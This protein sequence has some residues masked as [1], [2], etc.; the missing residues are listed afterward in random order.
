MKE[1]LEQQHLQTILLPEHE[2]IWMDKHEIWVNN[3]MFDIHTKKLEQGIYTF[4]GLYDEEE[5]E[6]VEWERNA[7]AKN[8]EQNKQLAQFLKSLPVFYTQ[9][10]EE[11]CPTLQPDFFISFPSGIPLKQFREIP[12]PPP[13]A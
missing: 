9:P 11:P 4:T 5:T 8:K 7:A 2:V 10:Y 1:K 3:S 6:L 12:T 13:R